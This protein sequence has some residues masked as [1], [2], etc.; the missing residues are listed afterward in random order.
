MNSQCFKDPGN[1]HDSFFW[2]KEVGREARKWA[3]KGVHKKERRHNKRVMNE[4]VDVFYVEQEEA[5]RQHEQELLQEAEAAELTAAYD[6]YSDALIHLQWIN[7]RRNT[8][9][10][11]GECTTHRMEMEAYRLELERELWEA[12]EYS[13]QEGLAWMDDDCYGE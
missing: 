10:Q 6:D 11:C 12:R 3:R 1:K 4:Q 2:D 5:I 8:E 9:C 13:I 7:S